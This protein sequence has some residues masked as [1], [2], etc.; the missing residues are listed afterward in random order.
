MTTVPLFFLA[1]FLCNFVLAYDEE[2]ALR[3]VKIAGAAYCL[4]SALQSFNVGAYSVPDFVPLSVWSNSSLQF[5][6]GYDAQHDNIV[7]SIRGSMDFSN[8]VSDFNARL[9]HPFPYA[10]DVGVHSGFWGEYSIMKSAL[11]QSLLSARSLLNV[12]TLVVV[13]H[14]SGGANAH[15]LSYEL[16]S[17]GG[18]LPGFIVRLLSTY[19][20][21]RVGNAA[22]SRSSAAS[23]AFR[24]DRATHYH[25]LFPHLPERVLGY[26]H[27]AQ[28]V[29]YDEEGAEYK[30]CEDGEGEDWSCSNSCGVA[31]KSVADHMVYLKVE[32]GTPPCTAKV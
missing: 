18:P 29:F 3:N 13:G 24:H 5:F 9:T 10:P 12:S 23:L 28:E 16:S 31:C 8:W 21:P 22:F 25:D 27:G 7:V 26:E 17:P 20:S 1:C 19:G 32:M 30:L 14:S 4:P 6:T 2:W 15:L 11:H